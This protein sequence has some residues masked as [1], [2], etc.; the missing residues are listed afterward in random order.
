MD[1]ELTDKT[2]VVSLCR[3]RLQAGISA[4]SASRE[5]EL[6][7]LKFAS[8]SPDNNW[9][10]P[11]EALNTRLDGNGNIARPTLT[12]NQLPQHILQITNDQQQNR[13][14]PKVIPA[15]GDAH[16]DVAEIL[17]GMIRHIEYESDADVAYDTASTNQVTYGE[18]YWR[19]ITRYVDEK[20]FDQE[21][22]IRRIR[23][24]FS[25][26]M[27][28][29]IQHPCG[30]DAEWCIILEDLDKKE[31]EKQYPKASPVSVLIEAGVGNQSIA[32]WI[33]SE[34]V[35]IAEYYCYENTTETLNLYPDGNAEFEGSPEAEHY[36][37]MGIEPVKSR[38]SERKKV[39]WYKTNGY[40]I[41]EETDWLG[42]YIP[43]I[44]VIGNEVEVEGQ[45]WISGIVRNAKDAQRMYNYHASN[46]VEML[47]LAPKAPFVGAAGQFE[48]FEEKWRDANVKPFPYLE[49]NAITD[50]AGNIL[51]PPQRSQ[52]PMTQSGIIAAKQGAAEDV[53]KTTGQYNASL[54]MPSNERSGKAILARQHEGDVGSYHYVTNLSRAVRYCG[55]QMV[56]LIPKIYD[57]HRVA[58]IMGEDGTSKMVR[59]DPEQTEAVREVQYPDGVIEKIYNPAV[60]KYGVMVIAGPSY[61]SK[62]IE[63]LEGMSTLLQANPEL[64]GIAGDLFVKNMD[65]PGAKEIAER[66]QKSINPELLRDDADPAVQQAK[67]QIEQL[68]QQLNHANAMLQNVS[69]SF[70]ARDLMIKEQEVQIKAFDA[71][72]KRIVAMQPA[73]P[74]QGMQ[75]EQA[76]Q[77]PQ[78]DPNKQMLEE[79]KHALQE[80]QHAHEFGMARMNA[81]HG[82]QAAEQQAAHASD[83]AE[84]QADLAPPPAAGG[85]E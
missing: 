38:P 65:W 25:V 45:V 49:Y 13:P 15:N 40:E 69:K 74:V 60:G 64:W 42:K 56:D 26:Y 63:A 4:T 21:L 61:A 7:D 16:T 73:N 81:I 6:E 46:E 80:K 54:G 33:G 59:L 58:M 19:I 35:R 68:M 77:V 78:I 85:D 5:N 84:Q 47:A 71:Q 44:R 37:M 30:E 29:M 41:L 67:M 3:S 79:S 82:A 62:R 70:E 20:S 53:K 31:Y 34:T 55:R 57:T 10:W 14:A 24:S 28:P 32:P 11:T 50:D 39:K 36:K 23:N 72:T 43:V 18:G 83:A 12:V 52:P 75:V 66:I 76:V 27:D 1:E 51:P 2:A 8:G 9:Q 17:N 22:I 48:N